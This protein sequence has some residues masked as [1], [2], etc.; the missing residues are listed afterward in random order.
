[1][2]VGWR[3]TSNTGSTPVFSAVSTTFDT[4]VDYNQKKPPTGEFMQPTHL[5]N[6]IDISIAKHMTEKL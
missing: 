3:L 4:S 5:T 2:D 6:L 1:M